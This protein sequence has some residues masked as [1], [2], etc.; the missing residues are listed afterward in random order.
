MV[1]KDGYRVGDLP[2]AVRSGAS[3]LL[4]LM[5]FVAGSPAGVPLLVDGGHD[6]S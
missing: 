2:G 3:A 4:P 5:V 1:V 6:G